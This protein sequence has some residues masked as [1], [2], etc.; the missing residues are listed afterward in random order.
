VFRVPV[1]AFHRF[2]SL[3]LAFGG[4]SGTG[5]TAPPATEP[6]ARAQSEP[7]AA[8]PSSEA[9]G[10]V[11]ARSSLDDEARADALALALEIGP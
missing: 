6:S 11:L 5:P 7:V 9:I 10:G 1:V 3:L 4:C 8:A 2:L